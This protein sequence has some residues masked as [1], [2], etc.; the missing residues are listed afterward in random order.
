MVNEGATRLCITSPTGGGKSRVTQRL[1][2]HGIAN[3]LTTVVVSNRKVLTKQLLN[4]FDRAGIEVGCRAAEFESRSNPGA[5]V[6]IVSSQTEASRVLDVREKYFRDVEF[7]RGDQLIIDE[8]HMNKGPQ[9]VAMIDEYCD[10][11]SAVAIAISATPVGIGKIYRDG[12]IV[13]GNNSQLRECGALVWAN[14]FEPWTMDLKKVRKSITGYTQASAE[15]EARA[16]W[17]Q[18]IVGGVFESWKKLNPDGR[19]SMGMAPGVKESLGI[20]Q[21]YWR[22]G[23]NAA[24]V[25]SGGIFVNGEYK[26]TTDPDDREELFAM[27]RDGRVPQIWNRFVLREGVDIPELYALQ[28]ATPIASLTS[29]VQVFG[30]VLRA[31]KGKTIARV[32]DHCGVM[33]LHGSPNDDRDK[34]WQQYFFNDDVN[35]ITKDSYERKTNP[36][37]NEPQTIT[38][39]QC[40]SVRDKGPKC[41]NVNCGFEHV[42]SV[43]KVIQES[44]ELRPTTGDAYKKRRVAMKTDTVQIWISTYFRMKKAKVPKSFRQALA[45]FKREN[46][47]YPPENLP[48]MPKSKSDFSRKIPYVEA[49]DLHER[50]NQ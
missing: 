4:G 35:A 32:I 45:L 27:V 2:E 7:H 49:K 5:K 18:H 3:G 10:K 24:H 44:G 47:Y 38:C 25:D 6:Q 28:L 26:K 12:L 48:F 37:N 34:D 13:A 16:I 11:Y 43:R 17:S 33:Q 36:E 1:C 15:K 41:G 8:A 21:E 50:T 22:R 39:P 46:G 9:T 14:R 19:P 23:V 30:R 20:A 29:A 42:Q 40:G 31:C